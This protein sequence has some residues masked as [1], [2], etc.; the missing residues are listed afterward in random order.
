MTKIAV[1]H[2]PIHIQRSYINTNF[3]ITTLNRYMEWLTFC[4]IEVSDVSLKFNPAYEPKS[5]RTRTIC[6]H[7]KPLQK[8]ENHSIYFIFAFLQ[9]IKQKRKE[10]YHKI[11]KSSDKLQNSSIGQTCGKNT[12]DFEQT[13]R[14]YNIWLAGYLFQNSQYFSLVS[15]ILSLLFMIF[16][17]F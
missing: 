8:R 15:Y 16:K 1:I 12:S 10:F 14:T 5:D 13:C 17:E 3:G 11:K 9:Q 6:K 2:K 7:K 4:R